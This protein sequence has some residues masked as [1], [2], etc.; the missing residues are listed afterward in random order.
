MDLHQIPFDFQL[1]PLD[2]QVEAYMAQTV[3]F[4]HTAAHLTA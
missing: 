3:A 2:P 4:I 1:F